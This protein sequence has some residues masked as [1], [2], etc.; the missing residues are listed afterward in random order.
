M[1]QSYAATAFK[2]PQENGD[3]KWLVELRTGTRMTAGSLLRTV[4]FA[5]NFEWG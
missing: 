1:Y 4:A 2:M 3:A 5:M